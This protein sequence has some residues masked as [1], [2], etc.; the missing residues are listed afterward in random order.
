MVTADRHRLVRMPIGLPRDTHHWLRLA[1]DRQGRHMA[2]IV[3]EAVEQYRE[4]TDP[5]LELPIGFGDT[6]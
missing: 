2:V 3:R 1:A 5:Q 6:Q 4:R